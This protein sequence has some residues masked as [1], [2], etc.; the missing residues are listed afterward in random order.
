VPEVPALTLQCTSCGD[1]L[2]EPLRPSEEALEVLADVARSRD[3]LRAVTEPARPVVLIW[4]PPA[5]DA[6]PYCDAVVQ[7]RERLVEDDPSVALM[8]DSYP[9]PPAGLPDPSAALADLSLLVA[10][11]AGA[12]RKA[13]ALLGDAI[14]ATRGLVLATGLAP[15]EAKGHDHD[16]LRVLPAGETEPDGLFDAIS[17]A[18]AA[19]RRVAFWRALDPEA[20]EG[21]PLALLPS[22][23]ASA[24][25]DDGCSYLLAL[26]E[27]STAASASELL[28]AAGGGDP[29]AER[30][31]ALLKAGALTEA[32]AALRLTEPGQDLLRRTLPQVPADREPD[33]PLARLFAE[34]RAGNQEALGRILQAG[35]EEA[36]RIAHVRL[37]PALRAKVETSDITQSVIADLMEGLDRF[38]FRGEPA[39]KGYLRR[40]VENK[41]RAKVDY[42]GAAK[43]DARR[44]R[45]IDEGQDGAI[46]FA[47]GEP[48]PSDALLREEEYERLEMSLEELPDVER[49]VLMLR[50]FEGMAHREIARRLG[51]PSVNAVHK[52]YGRAMARLAALM[53]RDG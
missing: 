43:R 29:L 47:S 3:R 18:L 22:H 19:V 51:R 45:P 38:E 9:A 44:D 53:G 36:R 26:A 34:A 4:L 7:I 33:T 25:T 48:A 1:R 6:P 41:I 30:L 40:L 12:L 10:P 50:V 5:A 23:R 11:G 46:E 37:G 35:V 2:D 8:T 31:H 16:R 27:R 17:L 42:F 14:P 20:P 39:W 49:E 32:D 24:H 13:L 21:D 15:E 28:E 52:L